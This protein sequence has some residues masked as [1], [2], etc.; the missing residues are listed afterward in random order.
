MW[1]ML[2]LRPHH[3]SRTNRLVSAVFASSLTL[4]FGCSEAKRETTDRLDDYDKTVW[5]GDE[6]CDA[7]VKPVDP[8]SRPPRVGTWNIRYFPDSQEGPQSDADEAT[9]VPWLACAITSLGVDV[10]AVQEFKTTP[11]ALEK[12]RELIDLL[13]S[14]TGGD[15]NIELAGCEPTEVQHPGFL[16]DAARVTG[17]HFRE[18]PLLNPRAE[19]SN[20]ASPGFAGY[21]AINGGPDF[22]FVSV[23]YESGTGPSAVEGRTHA[24]SVMPDVAAEAQTLVADTDVLFAGDFNTSGCDECSPVL[25]SEEEITTVV[26][27]FD[28][29]THP[30]RLIG[31]SEG[32]SREDG[33]NTFLLDHFAAADAMQ[34]VPTDGVATVSGICD[35]INCGRLRNW[36]EDA[37]KRLSDHCPLTLDLSASDQD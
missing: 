27:Q 8:S 16:Y 6:D 35:E 7:L 22:H 12:Q 10:L 18:V 25:T 26:A 14:R 15:W 23:H 4:A 3:H 31:A 9:D 11:E 24:V 29:P 1:G 36:H 21:F 30:L 13:N 19:C 20:V 2:D 37:R 28:E 5:T 32:C 34:E 33:D 17:Q